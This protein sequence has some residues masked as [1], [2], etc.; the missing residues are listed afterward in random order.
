[1][2][3]FQ[4]R[5]LDG[6][7]G[8]QSVVFACTVIHRVGWCTFFAFFFTLSWLFTAFI[9][10]VG[11]ISAVFYLHHYS[12][13]QMVRVFLLSHGFFWA[14][15]GRLVSPWEPRFNLA[16]RALSDPFFLA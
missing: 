11:S 4:N 1:M 2:R 10:P 15:G 7:S 5:G 6:L 8:G 12:P 16:D 9:G 13:F 14:P 3:H